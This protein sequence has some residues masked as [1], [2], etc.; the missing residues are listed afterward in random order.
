MSA[1]ANWLPLALLHAQETAV[2]AG[3][4]WTA[5]NHI[6][7]HRAE[8]AAGWREGVAQLTTWRHGLAAGGAGVVLAGWLW[9]LVTVLPAHGTHRRRRTGVAR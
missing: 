4:V 6:G 8:A 5:A 9:L 2:I 7:A 3:C 1:A